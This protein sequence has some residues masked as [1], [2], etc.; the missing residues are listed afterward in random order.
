MIWTLRNRIRIVK[1]LYD[2][3]EQRGQADRSGQAARVPT[4]LTAERRQHEQSNERR[5]TNTSA[6]SGSTGSRRLASL[7]DAA[8]R[9]LAR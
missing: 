8:V 1:P 4:G 6:E 5:T 9:V 3:G 7:A 2:Q